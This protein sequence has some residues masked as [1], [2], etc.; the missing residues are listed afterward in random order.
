MRKKAWVVRGRIIAQKVV[1]RSIVCKKAKARTC[2]QKM[3]DLP[4]ERSTPAAPF[5]FTSV[6]LFG[7]YH[8]KDDVKKGVT[9]KVWGVVFCCMASQAMHVQLANALSTENFLLAYLR[10]T[11][12]RGHPQKI[13]FD[14][15]ANF[16]GAKPVLDVMYTYPREQ[17]KEPLEE[18]AAKNQTSW[19]WKFLP[20][21]SPHWNGAAEAAV[22]ISK[23]A[24][25]SLGKVEVLMFSKFLTVLQLAANL[26]NERPIDARAQSTKE[27]IQYIT[28]NPLLLG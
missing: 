20:A 12:V 18:Y 11:A 21:N 14:P 17:N 5:K 2:Q 27:S 28:P 7:P 26:A 19:A 24:L 23:R 25:Q 16:V 4:G 3:G 6:E 15:G 8:V 22:R 13:W 1:D 10:S 9:M